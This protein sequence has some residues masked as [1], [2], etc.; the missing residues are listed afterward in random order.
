MAHPRPGSFRPW[1]AYLLARSLRRTRV[2][3]SRSLRGRSADLKGWLLGTNSRGFPSSRGQTFGDLV[4]PWA[5][6]V[7]PDFDL[8]CP[9][10]AGR[11]RRATHSKR[12]SPSS[13]HATTLRSALC[14]AR[15]RH[16]A[17]NLEPSPTDNRIGNRRSQ[18]CYRFWKPRVFLGRTPK[19]V[20]L[21]I[22]LAGTSRVGSGCAQALRRADPP[23]L[24][25]AKLVRLLL[26]ARRICMS[27][28]AHCTGNDALRAGTPVAPSLFG[29]APNASKE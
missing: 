28:T 12:P 25:R 16:T 23:S 29:E 10:T 4:A 21:P 27:S 22:P 9:G 8:L 3:F 1:P 18:T 19:S 17:R 2:R 13:Q 5:F 7:G 6:E 26:S 11:C 14:A 15:T 24:I 20:R